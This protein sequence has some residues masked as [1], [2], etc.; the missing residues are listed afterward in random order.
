MLDSNYDIRKSEK[1][2]RKS[3]AQP[4]KGGLSSKASFKNQIPVTIT[5]TAVIDNYQILQNQNSNSKK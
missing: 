1:P 5:Q 2:G 3:M 4:S